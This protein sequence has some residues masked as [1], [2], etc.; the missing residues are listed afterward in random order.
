MRHPVLGAN[1]ILRKILND[2]PFPAVL[3]AFDFKLCKKCAVSPKC[4][5]NKL[6]FCKYFQSGE[7]GHEKEKGMEKKKEK[8]KEKETG[9]KEEEK[10]QGNEK[11]RE[12]EGEGG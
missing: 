5:L 11:E 4:L 10:E 9:E 2:L 1:L 8:E 6:Y 7:S 3:C 12:K